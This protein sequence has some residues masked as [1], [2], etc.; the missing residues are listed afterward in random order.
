MVKIATVLP[1]LL[2]C[3][4]TI[5]QGLIKRYKEVQNSTLFYIMYS[6]QDYEDLLVTII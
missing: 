4:M 1:S 5:K 6:F 3:H 2:P